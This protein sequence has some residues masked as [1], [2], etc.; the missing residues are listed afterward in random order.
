MYPHHA[1]GHLMRLH[2]EKFAGAAKK[3][4]LAAL[5]RGHTPTEWQ[6]AITSCHLG[7]GEAHRSRM[8]PKITC[9]SSASGTIIKRNRRLCLK[10]THNIGCGGLT[11]K[12]SRLLGTLSRHTTCVKCASA[13]WSQLEQHA[14][15][16]KHIQIGAD[17]D[18]TSNAGENWR[19]IQGLTKTKK[20]TKTCDAIAH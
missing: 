13:L 11:L 4:E 15:T 9:A 16:A 18:T 17:V 14:Q 10:V 20:M 3:S 2:N 12:L 5:W 6:R 1:Q 8:C 7:C 19:Q